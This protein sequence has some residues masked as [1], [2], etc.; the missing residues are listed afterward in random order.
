MYLACMTPSCWRQID[1][2]NFTST[3]TSMSCRTSVHPYI[4]TSFHLFPLPH[5]PVPYPQPWMVDAGK[6]LRMCPPWLCRVAH[7]L[8]AMLPIANEG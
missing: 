3:S 2:V 5:S 4:R 1:L 6:T 7:D 8:D